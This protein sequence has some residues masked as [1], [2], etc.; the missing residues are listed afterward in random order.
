MEYHKNNYLLWHQTKNHRQSPPSPYRHDS[1]F[2]Y[3]GLTEWQNAHGHRDGQSLHAVTGMTGEWQEKMK[4]E[5]LKIIKKSIFRSVGFAARPLVACQSKNP[6]AMNIRIFNPREVQP[7]LASGDADTHNSW[8]F[9][10]WLWQAS[11]NVAERASGCARPTGICLRTPL[12][13]RFP[14]SMCRHY[15]SPS[16]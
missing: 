6:T 13:T 16:D 10:F 1:I 9:A 14:S 11:P 7:L 5:R 8:I 4:D 2:S 15:D 3:V 12:A